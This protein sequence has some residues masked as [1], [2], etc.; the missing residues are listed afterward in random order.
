[1]RCVSKGSED[2]P[3][4][5]GLRRWA[6]IT[7]LVVGLL[8][9]G[10]QAI[11]DTSIEQCRVDADCKTPLT[12]CT[13]E[14]LCTSRCERH[15]QCQPFGDTHA[16]IDD[17]CV[18]VTSAEC[19]RVVPEDALADDDSLLFGFITSK[20]DYGRPVADG[21]ELAVLEI[22]A[23][24]QT[25]PPAEEDRSNRKLALVMCAHEP[26]SP[27]QAVTAARHLANVVKVPAIVGSSYS[28]VTK[29]V[30]EAVVE[31]GVLVVSPSA[32]S[33]GLSGKAGSQDAGI[34]LG[35]MVRRT[36]PSDALQ[37]ELIKWLVHDVT[38]A[39][40]TSTTITAASDVRVAAVVKDDLAGNGLYDAVTVLDTE[41]GAAAAPIV[42]FEVFRKYD[43]DTEAWQGIADAV[44]AKNPHIVLGLGTGEFVDNV[45][46]L[47]EEAA[48]P[49]PWYVLPEGN[50][51]D[52]LLQLADEHPDW[53]LPTRVIGAAPGARTS[54]RY[55]NFAG[56]FENAFDKA[57]GNLAE[58]AYDTIYWVAYGILLSGKHYPSGE[59]LAAAMQ[60]VSCKEEDKVTN[61]ERPTEFYSFA[62][63]LDS[64]SCFDFEGV[65]GPL[66]FDA[67][68]G[69]AQS[70]IAMWCL[71]ADG[72][73]VSTE[74][75]LNDY[76]SVQN[77]A[78]VRCQEPALDLTVATWC[79]AANASAPSET[80]N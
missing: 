79:P 3:I 52:G 49:K 12:R 4:A 42:K 29:A 16:C 32:T 24:G 50:R 34:K 46:P 41:R 13:E 33:P 61:P 70:D 62:A 11:V 66:D 51:L 56:R 26:T 15:S 7:P 31:K 21:A 43:E 47:I 19:P 44:I 63:S 35:L 75:N 30:A 57:P 55:N 54:S 72:D 60:R 80:C 58:F 78:V 69:D 23:D 9:G 36:A 27:E 25:I 65:S 22:D 39:L 10:C 59:Q 53:N 14:K 45:V 76:Y 77:D 68:T 8:S 6:S 5:R 1:M 18:D 48:D 74:P 38:D 40:V 67:V 20:D 71:R 17:E 73:S 64:K 37:G 2:T 28:G